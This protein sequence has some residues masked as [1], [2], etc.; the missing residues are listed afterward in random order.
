VWVVRHRILNALR[1]EWR[2]LLEIRFLP[3][4]PQ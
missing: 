1:R 3:G 2:G 4:D